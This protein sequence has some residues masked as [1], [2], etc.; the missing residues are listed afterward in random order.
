MK[1][2]K[3]MKIVQ[4]G[5]V[6]SVPSHLRARLRML[7]MLSS[8]PWEQLARH[9]LERWRLFAEH[10]NLFELE[11]PAF[12]GMSGQ[13]LHWNARKHAKHSQPGP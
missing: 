12:E 8:I 13:L 5:I 10:S 2:P 3:N 4:N 1:P 11:P 7:C 6:T 9:S